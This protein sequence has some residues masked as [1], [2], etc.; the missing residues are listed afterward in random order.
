ML[1]PQSASRLPRR[2]PCK[3]PLTSPH[4]PLPMPRSVSVLPSPS[5]IRSALPLQPSSPTLDGDGSVD[6]D[7]ASDIDG[8]VSIANLHVQAAAAQNI[9][10]LVPLVLD[11]MSSHYNRW[12]DLVLL[13]LERQGRSQEL[14]IGGAM[15][16]TR[17]SKPYQVLVTYIIV[18]YISQ[19]LT[20]KNCTS[21]ILNLT[22]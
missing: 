12:R 15:Y 9:C 2:L 16:K 3:P 19:I 20:K 21:I 4:A 8:T 17:T 22:L 11:P 6:S 13:T 10:S 1:P 7:A 14:S 5:S 18:I